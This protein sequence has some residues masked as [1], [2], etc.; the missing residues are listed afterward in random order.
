M[1]K[2]IAKVSDDDSVLSRITRQI[3][4]DLEEKGKTA[5]NV[6]MKMISASL[7]KLRNDQLREI[8][9]DTRSAYQL[10]KSS[11]TVVASTVSENKLKLEKECIKRK[12]EIV[13]MQ[14]FNYESSSDEIDS[15]DDEKDLHMASRHAE[16]IIRRAP[17]SL[18]KPAVKRQPLS[19]Q[20][21]NGQVA[22]LGNND[23]MLT[24]TVIFRSL[25]EDI[26]CQRKLLRPTEVEEF[27]EVWGIDPSGSFHSNYEGNMFGYLNNLYNNRS[28][29]KIAR[30]IT[31]VQRE[32]KDRVSKLYSYPDENIGLEIL[33]LFVL[34]ILGRDTRAANIFSNKCDE[35]FK[36]T[37]AASWSSKALASAVLVLI[38]CFF[39]Y[40]AM[41]KGY[42][43]GIEWQRA[44]MSACVIQFVMEIFLIESIEC[45]WINYMVPSLV[46][47]E[48][49]SALN[50]LNDSINQICTGRASDSRYILNVPHY[51]FVSYNVAKSFP[52][53]LES[54]IVQSY[55]SHLPGE[56]CKIWKFN[57]S[58]SA[59]PSSI[60][61]RSMAVFATLMTMMQI[62]GTTPFIFQRIFIRLTQPV[63]LAGLAITFMAI[64]N[65]PLYIGLLSASVGAGL[66]YYSY[67]YYTKQQKLLQVESNVAPVDEFDEENEVVTASVLDQNDEESKSESCSKITPIFDDESDEYEEII[68]EVSDEE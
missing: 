47:A 42:V 50:A 2:D 61:L 60:S 24:N 62:V 14:S 41:I 45:L 6:N 58:Y 64:V 17:S 27:D 21:S 44:Y 48:V 63:M 10:A 37:K 3:Q 1:K 33:H 53:L 8:P 43:K 23:K 55:S 38:N 54:I 40:Y 32:S 51:L 66:L 5:S 7:H 12:S 31:R 46:A 26:N 9:E 65:N 49:T 20:K 4:F 18:S 52:A 34:D 28:D 67:K 15:S 25:V 30:E 13:R 19:V 36:K 29:A 16:P 59:V 56:L 22:P 39:L 11:I 35:D 68:E 57:R